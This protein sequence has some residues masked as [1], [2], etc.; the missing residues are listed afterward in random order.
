MQTKTHDSNT[1]IRHKAWDTWLRGSKDG[2]YGVGE[3][4]QAIRTL[5]KAL[6]KASKLLH[7]VL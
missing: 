1:Q 3:D 5:L 4:Y 6:H 2:G 7:D